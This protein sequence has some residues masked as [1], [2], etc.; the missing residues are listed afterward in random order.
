MKP[1][2]DNNQPPTGD[3]ILPSPSVAN[4]LDLPYPAPNTAVSFVLPSDPS[5]PAVTDYVQIANVGLDDTN[6]GT[7]GYFN[8]LEVEALSVD[9]AVID[10]AMVPPVGPDANRPVSTFELQ[11]A[12]I[13]ELLFNIIPNPFAPTALAPTD[14]W[15]IGTLTAVPEPATGSLLLIASAGMF[16]RRRR[17]QSI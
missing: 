14:D 16:M 10:S 8:G 12:G 15:T 4:F 6:Y 1:G 7:N 9:G 13:N 5:V 3:V 11:G 17:M 2:N